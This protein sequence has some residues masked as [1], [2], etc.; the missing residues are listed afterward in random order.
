[1]FKSTTHPLTYTFKSFSSP[2]CILF[3]LSEV[4]YPLFLVSGPSLISISFLFQAPT[5]R[6][7]CGRKSTPRLLLLVS[8]WDV[9]SLG[10]HFD[11]SSVLSHHGDF[12][13]LLH[14]STSFNCWLSSLPLFRTFYSYLS[15]RTWTVLPLVVIGS[16]FVKE[17]SLF[18]FRCCPI[19][20]FLFTPLLPSF[21]SVDKT[22]RRKSCPRLFP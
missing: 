16:I 15:T 9:S 14:Q 4:V 8:S 6:F 11:Y 1:M 19:P 18:F 10:V 12:G 17:T 21:I 5:S 7:Y 20:F 13:V 22:P 2:R 3:K